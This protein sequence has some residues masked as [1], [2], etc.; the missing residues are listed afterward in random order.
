MFGNCRKWTD[1]Y[2]FAFGHFG[3]GKQNC[4]CEGP[5]VPAPSDHKTNGK[6]KICDDPN[7]KPDE[8]TKESKDLCSNS[9]GRAS[10]A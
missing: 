4:S 6:D 7:S 1:Y 2:P 10:G 9:N 8:P 3:Y 5:R